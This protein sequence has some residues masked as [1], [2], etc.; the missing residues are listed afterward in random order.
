MSGLL[1][2][3]QQCNYILEM[4]AACLLF[5]LP[6]KKRHHPW[7]RFGAGALAALVVSMTVGG[8]SATGVA[9][10]GMAYLAQLI[11]VVLPIWLSCDVSVEDAVYG[12]I[13]AYAMQ[14][15]SSSLYILLCLGTGAGH[16]IWQLLDPATLG[17]YLLA[18]VP[19]YFLIYR[20]CARPL[21]QDGSYRASL[22]RAGGITVLV[23]PVAL[24]L[25]LV[26]KLSGGGGVAF[27]VCQ[28]YAM[29]CSAYVLWVQVS[30]SRE[31]QLQAEL[32]VQQALWE[33][34][35]EQYQLSRATIEVINRKCHDLKHQLAALRHCS[36]LQREESLREIEQAALIYDAVVQTGNEVLDTVLTEKSLVCEHRNIQWTC[37]ADGRGLAGMNPVDLYALVGNALDNA[38]ESVQQLQDP[39][40][41]VIGVTLF[42]RDGLSVLRVENYCETPPLFRDGL[43]VTTKQDRT[44]HGFGM[45]SMR[46]TAEKYGGSLSVQVEDHVF[47]L[48]VVLPVQPPRQEGTAESAVL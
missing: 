25:S 37:M 18:Y 16:D 33:K 38:I 44:V 24:F 15:F 36:E 32:K 34:E 41:R 5:A 11:V 29:L 6:L 26:A 13:C 20:L 35:K 2:R 40:K 46:Q 3:L 21:G 43:P 7:L 10:A 17:Y 1:D 14:H 28:V 47:V 45:K 19:P 8:I 12:T 22:F 42:R 23:L 27:L 48:C 4:L 39:A 31:V 9:E 30:Q